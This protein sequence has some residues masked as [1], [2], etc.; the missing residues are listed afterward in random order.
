MSNLSR[1]LRLSAVVVAVA[2]T[3]MVSACSNATGPDASHRSGYITSASAL[4]ATVVGPTSTTTTSV[5]PDSGKRTNTP[6]SGYNV[7][8]L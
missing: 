2:M 3:G 8:A 5:K 6:S 1:I 7:P 4:G